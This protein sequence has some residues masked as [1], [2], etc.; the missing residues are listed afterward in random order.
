VEKSHLAGRG[1]GRRQRSGLKKG[2]LLRFDY[3]AGTWANT[4]HQVGRT[5][6]DDDNGS[7]IITFTYH[8]VPSVLERHPKETEYIILA[9]LLP[10]R[11]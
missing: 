3:R 11:P 1:P 7:D 6:A 8:L 4:G 2:F 10:S 9:L 5:V